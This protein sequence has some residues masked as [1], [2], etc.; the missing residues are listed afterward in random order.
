MPL[1][2]AFVADDGGLDYDRILTEAIPIAALIG[3]FAAI[4]LPAFLLGVLFGPG[5]IGFL[6]FLLGQ[7]VLAVGGGIVLLHV[8]T[9]ALRIHEE[10]TTLDE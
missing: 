6:F 1:Q 7:F 4:S 9:Q 2:P 3:L 5:G 8:V 10:R